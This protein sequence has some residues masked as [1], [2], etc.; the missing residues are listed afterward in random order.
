MSPP[1]PKQ[2]SEIWGG[3]GTYPQSQGC[4]SQGCGA[5]VCAPPPIFHSVVYSDLDHLDD[6][7]LPTMGG[8]GSTDRAVSVTRAC[9]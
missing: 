8:C 3:R 9:K 7:D 6:N 4:Q 5:G 1:S 2:N